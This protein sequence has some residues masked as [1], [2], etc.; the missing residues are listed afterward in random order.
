MGGEGKILSCRDGRQDVGELFA[1]LT[2]FSL[3]E[4]LRAVP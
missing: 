2:D 1:H 3:T 4:L